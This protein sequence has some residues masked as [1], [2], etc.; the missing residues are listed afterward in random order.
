MR[1]LLVML[2]TALLVVG[3]SSSSENFGGEPS[4]CSNDGLV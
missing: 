1:K 4:S 3:C 2:S